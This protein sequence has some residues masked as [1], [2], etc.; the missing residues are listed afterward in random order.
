MTRQEVIG[1]DFADYRLAFKKKGFYYTKLYQTEYLRNA[2]LDS[3]SWL[4]ANIVIM[5]IY[6]NAHN[7]VNIL[8]ETSTLVSNI[9]KANNVIWLL[10]A[11]IEESVKGEPLIFITHD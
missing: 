2:K 4:N 8:S 3:D 7:A 6:L 9:L 11:V 1:V 5:T 10:T